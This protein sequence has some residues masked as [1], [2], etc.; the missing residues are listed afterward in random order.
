MKIEDTCEEGMISRLTT[1]LDKD[2]GPSVPKKIGLTTPAHRVSEKAIK[3]YE[4]M[5]IKL[6]EMKYLRG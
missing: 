2:A 3:L 5:V 1:I 6:H 4:Y